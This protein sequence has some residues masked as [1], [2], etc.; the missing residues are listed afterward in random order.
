MAVSAHSI[1]PRAAVGEVQI[2]YPILYSSD[3]QI[4]KNAA[5]GHMHTCKSFSVVIQCRAFPVNLGFANQ[6]K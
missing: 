1:D 4:G 6:P 5:F 2:K 3:K